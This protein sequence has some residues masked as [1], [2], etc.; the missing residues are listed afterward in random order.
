[1]ALGEPI[2]LRL[3]T[4]SQRH[5]EEAAAARG[6]PL[7]TYLRDRLEH[8]DRVIEQLAELRLLVTE[9]LAVRDHEKPELTAS[10][11]SDAVNS[12]MLIE[13]LLL[14]R[15]VV[16]ADKLNVAHGELRRQGI[17]IWTG[18]NGDKK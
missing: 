4:D 6:L 12:G 17:T 3:K 13:I 10:A 15:Q 11:H 5:Y 7:A 1:M 16:P 18:G 2:K 9:A 8:G 14:L